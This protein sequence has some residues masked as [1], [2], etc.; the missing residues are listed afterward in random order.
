MHK[1]HK[2][3]TAEIYGGKENLHHDLKV[4]T[5]K[6]QHTK[7]LSVADLLAKNISNEMYCRDWVSKNQAVNSIA[8]NDS[9][10]DSVEQDSCDS[11]LLDNVTSVSKWVSKKKN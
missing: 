1:L 10:S 5:G 8:Q 3:K 9:M 2:K 7:Q 11:S 4:N 6:G